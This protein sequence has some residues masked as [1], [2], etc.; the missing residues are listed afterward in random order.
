MSDQEIAEATPV[1]SPSR[2]LVEAR[3]KLGLSQKEVADR[4]YLT[5]TFI[6]Y[7]DDGEF[8]RLPKQAF[9]KGY[10][11]SYARVVEL[12]GDDIVAMYD[13]QQQAQLPAPEMKGVTE[14][15][16]GTASIT[17]PVMQ[18]G[19]IALTVF[20]LLI[21]LIWYLVSEP[22]DKPKVTVTQPSVTQPAVSEP[23]EDNGASTEDFGYVLSSEEAVEVIQTA[24][25]TDDSL[26]AEVPEGDASGV[27]EGDMVDESEV[28]SSGQVP[29]TES[30]QAGTDVAISED[31]S[32]ERTSNGA[33]S[34]IKVDAGGF[35]Q[36][37][38]SFP[39]E[40]WVEV[41]DAD[42][43]LVYSDLNRAGEVLTIYG[44]APFEL[45]LGKA[46]GVEMLYNGRPFDLVPFI[47]QDS[48]AKVTVSE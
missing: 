30:A 19:I 20:V 40:C 4:L 32:I 37:E 10:L 11:R 2:A 45:L 23:I 25:V 28:D 12:P 39:D 17:G 24:D 35:D 43:G 21:G 33:R 7:I 16:V 48:T 44:T 36:L 41:E 42:R 27:T 15:Q 18:T 46:A 29:T 47:G 9:V 38:L 31:V 6:R 8:E 14:E 13:A 26:D 3:E 5:T 34:F 1:P 22:D